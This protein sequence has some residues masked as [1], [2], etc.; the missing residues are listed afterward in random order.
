MLSATEIQYDVIQA[1]QITDNCN[2]HVVW[3]WVEI[4][5]D[6]ARSTH[7]HPQHI[8]SLHTLCMAGIDTGVKYP[9]Q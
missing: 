7:H 8:Y 2:V 5:V 6:T 4:V 3:R 1:C 9:T